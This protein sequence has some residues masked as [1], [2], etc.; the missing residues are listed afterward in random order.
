MKRKIAVLIAVCIMLIVC[1]CSQILGIGGAG[2]KG[3]KIEGTG[4]DSAEKA[5]LAYVEA[6]QNGDVDEIISTFAIETFI[7]NYSLKEHVNNARSYVYYSWPGG[8]LDS[9]DAYTRSINLVRRQNEIVVDLEKLYI[10]FSDI[11]DIAMPKIVG[12]NFY[13]DA[14]ELL[15]DITVDDWMEMLKKM[16]IGDVITLHDFEK[17]GK[18]NTNTKEHLKRKADY[19][20]CT[21]LLPLAVEVE[22]DG[23]D[24]YLCV[25]AARYGNK[26]YNHDAGGTLT[27]IMDGGANGILIPRD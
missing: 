7:D 1:G 25:D 10:E 12:G 24:Y 26:W 15:D 16:K 14:D 19:L 8:G 20:N 22:I 9:H 17:E 6:L 2:K 23:E 27:L 21:E 11:D 13:K 3:G 5:V 18:I 4:F